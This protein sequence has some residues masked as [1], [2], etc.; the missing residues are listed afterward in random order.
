M[1]RPTLRALA[2]K[3][4]WPELLD[5]IAFRDPRGACSG[6]VREIADARSCSRA[7]VPDQ[8]PAARI[9]TLKTQPFP[10]KFRTEI[11][12]PCF[13]IASRVMAK[14]SPSPLLFAPRRT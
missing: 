7:C 5:S 12:P 9:M 2:E 11:W 3:G 8:A 4:Y 1:A 14:P 6:S 10:G 13:S